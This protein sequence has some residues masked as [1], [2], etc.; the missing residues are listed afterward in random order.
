[1]GPRGGSLQ[2][3][4]IAGSSSCAT[5]LE[6]HLAHESRRIRYVRA[7]LTVTLSAIERWPVARDSAPVRSTF[8]RAWR[9]AAADILNTKVRL[10]AVLGLAGD[11][12]CYLGLC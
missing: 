7:V 4:P 1:M 11:N 12:V 10:E 8:R 5:R 3:H 9:H 2:E 6:G